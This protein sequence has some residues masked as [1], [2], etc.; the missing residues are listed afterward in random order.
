MFYKDIHN[1]ILNK[2]D[3]KLTRTEKDRLDLWRALSL[4][5]LWASH[6]HTDPMQSPCCEK[7]EL[8]RRLG[9]LDLER[10]EYK[11]RKGKTH[12]KEKESSR[13]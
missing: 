3:S 11:P 4:V 7:C 5:L 9:E 8:L 13:S 6:K 12:G 10:Y 1:R 2:F